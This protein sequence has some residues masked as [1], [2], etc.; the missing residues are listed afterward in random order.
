MWSVVI[1]W[2]SRV[3]RWAV[4]VFLLAVLVRAVY[5]LQFQR[6]P[7]SGY[8]T[9]D[10][11]YY[12]EWA[13]RISEG[14]IV[15][16]QVFEQSPLY[17][18]ALGGFFAI[19]G[20]H[21]PWILAGQLL[22]GALTAV[23][24]YFC[25]RRLFNQATATIAGV[26]AAIYGPMVFYECLVMKSF[27]SPFLTITVLYS[28]LRYG[29]HHK[30]RW[31]CLAGIAIGLACL[32]REN[33]I[34][35]LLGMTIWV[36]RARELSRGK[37]RV[38][39]TKRFQHVGVLAATTFVCFVP[40]LMHN[41][42]AGDEFVLVTAGGGEVFYMA[43]GPGAN[44]YYKAPKFVR[45]NPEHE[46]KD[47]RREAKRR[48]K[49]PVTPAESSRFWFWEG[50]SSIA[51][52]PIRATGL[53]FRKGRL[54]LND[55]EANDSANFTATRR[56]IGVLKW[57]PGFG[58]MIGLGLLGMLVCLFDFRKYELTFWVIAA[59][60]VSVLLLYNFGRFRLGLMPVWCLF[61][62]RGSTWIF[63]AR[64]KERAPLKTRAIAVVGVLG[65]TVFAFSTPIGYW[66]ETFAIDDELYL[67][68]M[69]SR[70]K[71]FD[72][73][74]EHYLSA[75]KLMRKNEARHPTHAGNQEALL[76]FKAGETLLALKQE[77]HARRFYRQAVALPNS[78]ENRG[79]LLRGWLRRLLAQ[80]NQTL[81]LP[82]ELREDLQFVSRE[83]RTADPD[84][85]I[86]WAISA[87]WVSDAEEKQQISTGLAKAWKTHQRNPN[88]VLESWF[89]TG[90]VFL[91][92]KENPISAANAASRA[93]ELTPNH[94]WRGDLQR[95]ADGQEK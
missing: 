65:V 37:K 53:T 4:G 33:H 76:A 6:S 31:L 81:D 26:L 32:V 39:Q 40:S 91:I 67:A 22:I 86:Y 17:S 2:L 88:P 78:A 66:D 5:F 34:L 36:W 87:R 11:L 8:Y 20:E 80:Q 14:V 49:K 19:F 29:D 68:E 18:Y 70:A 27:L 83:L 42:E 24:V 23:L 95:L 94:P 46:H 30:S 3:D 43:H 93:L 1:R 74:E 52:H 35:L 75:M 55:F 73:T 62:A 60:V 71:D 58:S 50:V 84:Q 61:A 7:L 54:F 51:S 79:E 13:K 47:F 59:H 85:V 38:Q 9:L 72:Q 77:D 16:N 63:Q 56:T 41:F 45:P 25:G 90:M 15:Q 12:L 44:G 92:E 82:Q 89:L 48:L 21:L 28:G 10:H 64:S 57:L 69:S